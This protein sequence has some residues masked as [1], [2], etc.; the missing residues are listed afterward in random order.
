[1]DSLLYIDVLGVIIIIINIIKF[2]HLV[3]LLVFN[4]KSF[5]YLENIF[6]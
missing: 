5:V 1:M 3:L 2:D 6:K 4:N